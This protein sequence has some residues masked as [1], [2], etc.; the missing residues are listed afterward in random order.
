MLRWLA[1]LLL[2]P[3]AALA[4]EPSRSLLT[5]DFDGASFGGRWDLALRDLEDAVGLD[6][7]GD[8][9]VTWGEVREREAEIVAYALPR[10]AVT[11][12][13]AACELA[14][15]QAGVDS[16]GDTV[17]AV[18]E[19]A[20]RCAAPVRAMRIDYGLMFDVDDAHRAI[21]TVNGPAGGVAAVLSADER[22]FE[23][24]LARATAAATLASFIAE[25]VV[26]IWQGYDHLAFVTLLLLPIVLGTPRSSG[27]RDWRAA[28]LE[29]LRVVT[30]FTAA[31]SITL[32]L[33]ALQVVAPPAA[34]VEIAIAA[35]VLAAAVLNLLP[36]APRLGAKL[37]FAFG[38]VHGFGFAGALG[39][40]ADSP[41]AL[42][43]A[44]FNLGVELGQLA[45][46]AVLVPLL[47]AAR[48]AAPRPAAI[49]V[50]ASL[51]CAVV[52]VN[53]IAE[54]AA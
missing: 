9:S 47:F 34:P 18:L 33:A 13:G 36:R 30:A 17:F 40:I 23:V 1:L 14:A 28:A 7:D 51:L 49:N 48:R 32:A 19:V 5:L 31:H 39:D 44:G 11:A 42:G 27:A 52:A 6:A 45:V 46:V 24:D 29:V 53:W 16:R 3:S 4:H 8:L 35:S 15:S 10:L 20:G 38:L 25:G 54:R 26:H 43:L 37:A 41:R 50:A 21:V 22:S 12:D 2:L